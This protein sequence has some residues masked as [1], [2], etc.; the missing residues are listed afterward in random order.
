MT[1]ELPT[2]R[3]IRDHY[4]SKGY[5]HGR[6]SRDEVIIYIPDGLTDDDLSFLL[7]DAAERLADGN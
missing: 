7:A 5:V 6:I 1:D 3:I 2:V 4:I